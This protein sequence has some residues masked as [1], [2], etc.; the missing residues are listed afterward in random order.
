MKALGEQAEGVLGSTQWTP[1]AKGKD[2]VFGTAQEYAQD[3]EQRFGETAE[4]HSAEAAAACLALVLGVEKAGSTDPAKVRDAIAGLD[5]DSFFGP[6]K[7]D[8]P[9]RT[10][11][12]RCR[13]SRSMKGK[14]VTIY[15]ADQAAGEAAV[16]RRRVSPRRR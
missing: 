3:F 14:P 10:A 12:S 5:T 6:I 15:P 13:R 2:K 4:Y 7:F 16:A 8:A 1:D 9:A 11:R